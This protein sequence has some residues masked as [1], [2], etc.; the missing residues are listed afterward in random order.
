MRQLSAIGTVFAVLVALSMPPQRVRASI[1]GNSSQAAATQSESLLTR[2]FESLVFSKMPIASKRWHGNQEAVLTRSCYSQTKTV[3]APAEFAEVERTIKNLVEVGESPSVSVVVVNNGEV[4]WDMAY[5]WADRENKVPATTDTMYAIGSVSKS[6]TG[7]ALYALIVHGLVNANSPATRYLKSM[8]L[9]TYAG[10]PTIAELSSMEGGVP[11]GWEYIGAPKIP[12]DIWKRHAIVAFAPGSK[13][14]Y[15]NISYGVLGQ[16]VGDVTG[17]PLGQAVNELVFQKL[18]MMQTVLYPSPARIPLVAV[19]YSKN[20]RLKGYPIAPEGAAGFSA[21][22]RDLARF[23]MLHAEVP[24]CSLS[25]VTKEALRNSH[26]APFYAYGWGRINAPDRPEAFLSNG[27]VE[28]GRADILVV[29]Q[30]RIVIAIAQNTATGS[31]GADE[32]T[33]AIADRLMPGFSAAFRTQRKQFQAENQK[34]PL[35]HL[36]GDW[37]G[38]LYLARNSLPVVLHIANERSTVQIGR[39]SPSAVTDLE[40]TSQGLS[41]EASVDLLVPWARGRKPS[42]SFRLSPH[43]DS[44]RGEFFIQTGDENPGIGLPNYVTLQRKK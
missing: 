13:F 7:T 27:E 11:H 37:K 38:K 2:Y 14:D 35:D 9:Q 39:R 17:K 3:E 34:L 5:G 32:L 42:L 23:G 21:S 19:G 41:G 30:T 6:L 10:S 4:V 40:L 33:F 12:A 25:S 28:G 44:M 36:S 22:A 1:E 8:K 26:R 20:E 15:S 43:E 24:G 18:G 29:P 31:L 16:I